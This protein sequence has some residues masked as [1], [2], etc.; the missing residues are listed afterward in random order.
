VGG[1]LGARPLCL[2]GGWAWCDVC[3]MKLLS[4]F[5]CGVVALV[6]PLRAELSYEEKDGGYLFQCPLDGLLNFS[7]TWTLD[8]DALDRQ[9]VVE[10]F[11]KNP[12]IEWLDSA[13]TRA[14]FA[15]KPFNNIEVNLTLMDKA[16]KVEEATIDFVGGKAARVY[17]SLF[18]RGDSGELGR[19]EFDLLWKQVG[20][21]LGPR[22]K[23]QP[24][25]VVPTAASAVKTMGFRWDAPDCIAILEH[26]LLG[27][28][29]KS[30]PEFLRLKLA[31]PGAADWATGARALGQ[32]SSTVGR[33][34]LAK[35]VVKEG[36]NTYISGVPMVDQGQKGYCVVASCQRMFEYLHVPCDQHELAQLAQSD[37]DGG[38]NPRL[39]EEALDKVDHKYQTRLKRII[40]P[41]DRRTQEMEEKKFASVVKESVDAGIPLLWALDVGR[42]PEEPPLTAQTA[43]GHMRMI[44]GYNEAKAELIFSDSWGAGHERKRMKRQH[45][46]SATH[47]LY[48]LVPRAL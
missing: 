37:A 25:P 21:Q 48:Q 6:G 3:S 27:S 42:F 2:S 43:G 5:C 16:L 30:Q 11:K 1:G 39:M 10:R 45:G 38:T 22:L 41:M 31:S 28:G 46:L 17:V 29:G 12:C 47:G 23:V 36:G 19:T 18:N 34:A 32:T 15:R 26:N 4:V 24:R 7:Q 44:I 13:R 33:A 9:F 8:A 14:R 20:Q 35:N 40:S